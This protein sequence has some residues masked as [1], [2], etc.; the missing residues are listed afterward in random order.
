MKDPTFWILARA[1]GLTAYALLT[2]SVLAGLVVKSKPFGKAVRQP[3]VTD[4]HRFLALLGLGMIALHGVALV[5]DS[6]VKISPTALLVPGLSPYRPVWTAFGVV[7]AELMVL[8]YVSFALRR[9]IGGRNWRRLHWLTYAIF[10]LAT[11]HGLMAGTD[12]THRWA[13]WLYVGAIG[14][15]ATATAWRA[16]S[17]LSPTPSLAPSPQPVTETSGGSS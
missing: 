6:T 3:S 2:L 11:V 17:T 15:V 8:V 13:L 4:L 5:L 14:A 12:S 16:F 1:S 9:R 10:G 7:S